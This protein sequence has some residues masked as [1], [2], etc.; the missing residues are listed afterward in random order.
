MELN[1]NPILAVNSKSALKLLLTL[2]ISI[3]LLRILY[4]C[5]YIYIMSPTY[6]EITMVEQEDAPFPAITLCPV[7]GFKAD[8]LK[9]SL[10][11]LQLLCPGG[12]IRFSFIGTW[13]LFGRL[14][15]QV[16]KPFVGLRT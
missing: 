3:W 2:G 8:V 14:Y 16:C 5:F 4:E 13:T 10:L 9:V 6:T 7:R 12:T 1:T 15:R 11:Y